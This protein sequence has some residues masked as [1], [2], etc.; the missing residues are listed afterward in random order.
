MSWFRTTSLPRKQR[1]T[2]R[3]GTLPLRHDATGRYMGISTPL[4]DP[5]LYTATEKGMPW[6]YVLCTLHGSTGIQEVDKKLYVT[7]DD[8]G[9]DQLRALREL[10]A[11]WE[12]S[13]FERCKWNLRVTANGKL[14][15]V[16]AD[17]TLYA[18]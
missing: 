2:S 6:N 11:T 4:N 5:W 7:R 12:C 14:V 9:N 15:G 13:L 16:G 18:E 8:A 3:F 17:S 1:H 10:R